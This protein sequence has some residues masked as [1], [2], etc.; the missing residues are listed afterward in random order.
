MK[1]INI[2]AYTEDAAQIEAIKA[3][4]KAFKIK[5]SITKA[6]ETESP[7]NSEFVAMVKKGEKQILDGKGIKMSVADFKNLCK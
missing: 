7:Y 6:N 3:V 4:I 1:A 2:T 5:Y